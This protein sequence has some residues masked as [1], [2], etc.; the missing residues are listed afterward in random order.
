MYIFYYTFGLLILP[1]F[2]EPRKI[3]TLNMYILELG[4]SIFKI[5]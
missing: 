1:H 2:A 5:I 4:F 3:E